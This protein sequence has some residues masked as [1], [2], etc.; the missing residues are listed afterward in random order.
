MKAD[1]TTTSGQRQK[2]EGLLQGWTVSEKKMDYRKGSEELEGHER[3]RNLEQ[4][5]SY[6]EE[7]LEKDMVRKIEI[8]DS[9]KRVFG[10]ANPEGIKA[11][12][13]AAVVELE[14]QIEKLK[15]QGEKPPYYETPEYRLA[16]KME[17]GI[18]S[19]SFDERNFALGVCTMHRTLQQRFMNLIRACIIELAESDTDL[20]NEAAV[21]MCRELKPIVEKHY[22]PF[23]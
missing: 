11:M 17:D 14:R 21:A 10:C 7:L 15:W 23:I 2:E 3:L 6:Y 4:N 1:K 16:M 9:W 8:T 13:K 12:L 22:L 5:L 20:R 18:N 19:F